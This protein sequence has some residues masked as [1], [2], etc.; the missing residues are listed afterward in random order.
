MPVWEARDPLYQDPDALLCCKKI[1]AECKSAG[2]AVPKT[3]PLLFA[4][5]EVFD[6]RESATRFLKVD[7]F[8]WIYLSVNSP[9]F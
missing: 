9:V 7:G 1:L 5:K 6:N 3:D 2:G 8:N 4:S